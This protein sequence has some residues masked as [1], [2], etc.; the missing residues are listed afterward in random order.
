M[1][2]GKEEGSFR[3]NLAGNSIVILKVQMLE[4]LY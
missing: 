1:K 3:T 2:A 4:K